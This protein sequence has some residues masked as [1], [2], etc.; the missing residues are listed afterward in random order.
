M[1]IKRISLAVML[2]LGLT[3]ALLWLLGLP[4]DSNWVYADL[5]VDGGNAGSEGVDS[6][7]RLQATTRVIAKDA[8]AHS[9]LSVDSSGRLHVSYN[10]DAEDGLFYAFYQDSRWY[11]ET[12]D[13]NGQIL[14]NSIAVDPSNRP[15]IR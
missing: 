2:G 11:T 9:S 1:G 14:R 6:A 3:F 12:V 13:E 5:T 8:G 7:P 4:A 15:H 10:N